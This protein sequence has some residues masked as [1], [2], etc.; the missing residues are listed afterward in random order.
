MSTHL[1]TTILIP[2]SLASKLVE[3]VPVNASSKD[4]QLYQLAANCIRWEDNSWFQDK[5]V[6]SKLSKKGENNHIQYENVPCYG[7]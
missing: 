2:L 1:P 4:A 3:F 5:H 6:Q 7:K